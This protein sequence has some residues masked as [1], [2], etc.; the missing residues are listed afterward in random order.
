MIGP[1]P[2]SASGD[3]HE[4]RL[5]QSWWFFAV[6]FFVLGLLVVL[7]LATDRTRPLDFVLAGLVGLVGLAAIVHRDAVHR[8]EVGRRGEAE[9]LARILQG[10]SR[11]I[12]PDAIVEA[13]AEEVGVATAA[14][15]VVV[16]RRRAEGDALEATLVSS[17]AGV[18]SST[19]LF[20]LADLEDPTGSLPDPGTREPVAV[21]VVVPVAVPAVALSAGAAAAS[22][23]VAALA[24]SWNTGSAQPRAAVPTS[25][26]PG[27]I[28]ATAAPGA[29]TS[30]RPPAARPPAARPPAP[31]RI[32]ERVAARA[33]A[34]YGLRNTLAEPLRS[35]GRVVGAIV[36]SRRGSDPW[37]ASA[38]RILAGAAFEASAALARANH[39]REAETRATTDAL[40]GLPNR[41][42]FD[43][44]CGLLA[45]R[46]RAGDA[47]GVLLVDIDWFKTV[48]DTWGHAAGDE[49][50]RAVARAIVAAVREE[51][52]PARYGGEEFAVL[53]RNPGADVA[54]DV[55]ERVRASVGRLDLRR[56]GPAGVTVSIGV[57]VAQASDQPMGEIVA[58]ADRALYHAKR[59]GRDRVVAGN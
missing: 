23:R 17:R 5:R 58:A 39:H 10:L 49:V 25:V 55:A 48:N 59:R 21:P 56:F 22:G 40:T 8:I 7:R 6:S 19:T 44:F 1:N 3:P 18:P 15:H 16:V 50:L 31:L 9:S 52:V 46:R 45:R 4:R 42:Y 29:A 38:R 11:S 54:V 32:A 35:E 2:S 34:A 57:A 51:D 24:A 12:S 30:T 28:A 27:S 41:R 33:R 53:L 47:V 37:P 20:P 43:E 36:L 14:D 13:I 26:S